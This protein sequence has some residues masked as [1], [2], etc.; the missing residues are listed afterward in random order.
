MFRNM[1][2]HTVFYTHTDRAKEYHSEKPVRDQVDN[3]S[4]SI[5]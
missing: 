2:S 4:S 1:C 3:E 5:E